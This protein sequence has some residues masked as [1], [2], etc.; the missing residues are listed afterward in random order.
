VANQPSPGECS[1]FRLCAPG[2]L[3]TNCIGHRHLRSSDPEPTNPIFEII[4]LNIVQLG[5]FRSNG[6][7]FADT[8]LGFNVIHRSD[9]PFDKP[10]D[11]LDRRHVGHA[12]RAV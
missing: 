10:T 1:R 5:I 8:V 6:S 3:C 4:C 11:G 2:Q 9:E 7:E 12:R